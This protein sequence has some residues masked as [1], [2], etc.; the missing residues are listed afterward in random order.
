MDLN[1][2]KTFD[3][4]MKT[5]SVNEA[6]D[7]LGITAPAVSQALNRLREQYQDPLLIRKGRGIAPTNFAVEL[8]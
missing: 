2:L 5:R 8:H 7:S 6:A 4:V 1:L 3:V